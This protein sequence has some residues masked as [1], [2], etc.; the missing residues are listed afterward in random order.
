MQAS[1][2]G[3][4]AFLNGRTWFCLHGLKQLYFS[5]HSPSWFWASKTPSVYSCSIPPAVIGMAAANKVELV[6]FH[7][8]TRLAGQGQSPGPYAM[9]FIFRAEFT[10]EEANICL[11]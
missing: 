5:E 11:G 2:R 7:N 1:H 6:M 8:A 10:I 3:L 9:Q 4:L